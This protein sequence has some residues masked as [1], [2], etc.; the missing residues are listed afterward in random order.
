MR[1]ELLG[2]FIMVLTLAIS[3]GGCAGMQTQQV[4]SKEQLLSAAGFQM[5]YAD[6]PQRQAQIQ[7]VPQHKLLI[8]PYKGGGL[9]YVYRDV[10]TLYMGDQAAYQ[11]YQQLAVA[12][13]IAQE[14]LETA[15]I[16][17]ESWDW[18]SWGWGPYG[19][20]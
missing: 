8:Y 15:Q 1:K 5:R 18:G 6:T 13:Q 19:P 16:N 11:R 12:K 9:V 2:A 14:Q 3:L 4:E 17:E 10:N 7:T 20:Q